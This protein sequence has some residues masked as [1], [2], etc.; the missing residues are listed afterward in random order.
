[1]HFKMHR[2][3]DMAG[4]V[5]GIYPTQIQYLLKHMIYKKNFHRFIVVFFFLVLLLSFPTAPLYADDT[6]FDAILSAGL[7]NIGSDAFLYS[8]PQNPYSPPVIIANAI[9]VTLST[10]G[11][12][13]LAFIVYAG[14]R[15]MTASGKEE[16][17]L[18][19]RRLIIHAIIGLLIILAAY[20]ITTFI[21]DKVIFVTQSNPTDIPL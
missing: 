18:S 10:L 2:C 19:A 9:T 20:S 13:F 11:I 5:K 1:M 3:W 7:A 6:L 16:T 15:W 14:Y 21:F 17:I 4:K 8:N 12:V